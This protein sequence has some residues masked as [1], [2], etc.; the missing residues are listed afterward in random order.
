MAKW[1]RTL[2]ILLGIVVI[3]VIVIVALAFFSG[4]P[5]QYPAFM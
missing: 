1:K 4:Q 2:L 3:L 5:F